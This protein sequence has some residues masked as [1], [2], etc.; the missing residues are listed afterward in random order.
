MQASD[1]FLAFR[2]ILV[3]KVLA[4]SGISYQKVLDKI[5]TIASLARS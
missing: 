5:N 1:G 4:L 2:L 3:L